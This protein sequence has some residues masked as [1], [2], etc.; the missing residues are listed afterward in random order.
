MNSLTEGLVAVTLDKLH[1]DAEASDRD[2]IEAMM[3]IIEAPGGSPEQ[4]IAG[5]LAQERT[6][7]RRVYRDYADNFLAVSPKYGRFLYAIARACKARRI[8]EFGTSMGISTI[9][10]AAALR[11]NGGGHLIGSELEGAK[12]ARARANL[13]AAG[14]DD[15]V[16]IREGDALETL[17]DVGGPVDLLLLDGAFSLYLPVLKMIEP[18]LSPGAAILGENAFDPAYQDYVR[19]PANGYL[20]RALALDEGRGNEFTVRTARCC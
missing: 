6:D 18:R 19:K 16:E 5:M 10:L 8:V 9:Y 4:A 13:E 2:H 12:V 17:K 11:D 14:L 15:L 3:A 7:Y 1:Q 20:S